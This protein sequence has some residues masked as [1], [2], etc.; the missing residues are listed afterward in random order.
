[1]DF[2]ENFTKLKYY[3]RYGLNI[4][5]LDG[6]LEI[7]KHPHEIEFPTPFM[8]VNLPIKIP[9][10]SY[11]SE[12]G[13]FSIQNLVALMQSIQII[14]SHTSPV[15]WF[16]TGCYSWHPHIDYGPN[17]SAI[18][19]LL[20]SLLSDKKIVFLG[21]GIPSGQVAECVLACSAIASAGDI[22]PGTFR[23]CFPYASLANI[24]ALLEV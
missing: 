4:L 16:K 5:N 21:H 22:I 1:M 2:S 9:L 20:F 15:K 23:R 18:S 10:L 11:V 14:P 17:T 7:L 3:D 12:I 8:G 19:I 24:D 6:P 13:G